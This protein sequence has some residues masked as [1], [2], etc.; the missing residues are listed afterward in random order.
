MEEKANSISHFFI[1]IIIW[2]VSLFHSVIPVILTPQ[3][4]FSFEVLLN[5]ASFDEIR[6]A[7]RSFPPANVMW[8]LRS[9]DFSNGKDVADINSSSFALNTLGSL[10]TL[11]LTIDGVINMTNLQYNDDGNFTCICSNRYGSSA[12]WAR[13]RVKS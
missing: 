2:F 10:D 13:L 1:I 9:E 4:E 7:T 8:T 5:R 11:T 3:P 6:C 12:Q